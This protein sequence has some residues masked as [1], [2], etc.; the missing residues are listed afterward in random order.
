MT[1]A[2]FARAV[3]ATDDPPTLVLLNSC[4]SAGQIENLV[5]SVAPF[6]I[7]MADSIADADA[8]NYAAQFYAAIANGQSIASAHAAGQARLE[9]DGLDSAEFPTLA[10]ALGADPTSAVLV[11]PA[12]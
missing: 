3:Q 6:A 8:I 11:L 5:A 12:G 7:G 1:A 4:D 9:L 10:A 2:A